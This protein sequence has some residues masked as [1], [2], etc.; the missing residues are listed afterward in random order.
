MVITG[1]AKIILPPNKIKIISK[2]MAFTGSRNFAGRWAE[3][4]L[5]ETCNTERCQLGR[6]AAISPPALLQPFL[7]LVS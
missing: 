6:G 4:N 5:V 3:K 1:L 7:K 2:R